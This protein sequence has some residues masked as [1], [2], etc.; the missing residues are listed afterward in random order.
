MEVVGSWIQS[1]VASVAEPKPPASVGTESE[2]LLFL[3]IDGVICCNFE[4]KLEEDKLK[5]LKRIHKATNCKVV[6]SSDW[7]RNLPAKQKL[8]RALDRLGVPVV[9]CTPIRSMGHKIIGRW[10]V[11]QPC[12]PVEITD[13]L[14][15]HRGKD[16]ER[17]RWVA[18]DDRDLVSE[19]GGEDLVG[20]VVKTEMYYGLTEPHATQ[21][22]Q[23]LRGTPVA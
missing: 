18:I 23:I 13:W 8:Q 12:R 20:H 17:T 2:R 16:L 5:Q 22:I 15:K 21:A 6:I 7:R 3:D 14:K 4:C 11:E 9:G 19:I 1:S 10:R